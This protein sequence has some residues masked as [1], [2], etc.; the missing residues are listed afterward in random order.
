MKQ[1][2]IRA[3]FRHNLI[4][5][6]KKL[7]I[8]GIGI[9]T[10]LGSLK[11]L[12]EVFLNFP[13]NFLYRKHRRYKTIYPRHL[14]SRKD[15]YCNGKI[16]WNRGFCHGSSRVQENV[17]VFCWEKIGHSD[18]IHEVVETCIL[19]NKR[20]CTILEVSCR[21]EKFMLARLKVSSSPSI[22]LMSAY[23]WNWKWSTFAYAIFVLCT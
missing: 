2:L 17:D 12:G 10:C 16:I 5:T 21:N 1:K 19:V 20:F 11:L 3:F 7:E 22:L 18:V 15:I 4:F 14:M 13:S 8:G 9:N 23:G 6:I